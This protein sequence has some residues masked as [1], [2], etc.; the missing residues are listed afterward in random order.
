[1]VAV[2]FDMPVTI[3]VL[4]PMVTFGSV[5]VHS[6]PAEASLRVTDPLT[7]TC[8]IPVIGPGSGFTVT[9]TIAGHDANV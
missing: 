1:M 2:P 6:P 8:V 4:N 9:F 3:P 5:Q 7:H